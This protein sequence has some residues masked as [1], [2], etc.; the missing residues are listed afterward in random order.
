VYESILDSHEEYLIGCTIAQDNAPC[1]KTALIR[2]W[3]SIHGI[4]TLPWPSCS[5]DLNPIEHV[6]AIMK[7]RIQ[8][9]H[10][11]SKGELW[12]VLTRMWTTFTPFFVRRFV[13]SMPNRVAAVIA[14]KGGNTKY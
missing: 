12:G 8:G 2:E 9:F 11:K 10:Y 5:P 13:D 14:A 6:W 3:M 1:H 7:R 4:D